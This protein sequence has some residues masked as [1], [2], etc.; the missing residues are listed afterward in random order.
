MVKKIATTS[1]FNIT[2]TLAV[3]RLKYACFIGDL[4]F[5]QLQIAFAF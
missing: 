1:N 2:F 5:F 4:R 3:K